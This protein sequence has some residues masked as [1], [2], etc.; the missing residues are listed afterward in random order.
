MVV[1]LCKQ[2]TPTEVARTVYEHDTLIWRIL[3]HYVDTARKQSDFSGVTAIGFDET[4]TKG[5][6]FIT[7]VA[8]IS[9][10]NHKVQYATKGKDKGAVDRFKED[11]VAHNGNP[12]N[13]KVTT[14]DMAIGLID[15]VKET[16]INKYSGN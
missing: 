15:H 8:D 14:S 9:P 2:M 10:D 6:E 3:K 16:F 12:E 7:V 1:L 11:F 13:I 4:S 5:Q